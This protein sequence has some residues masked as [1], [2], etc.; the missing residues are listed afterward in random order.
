MP[1]CSR[2]GDVLSFGPWRPQA[3]S[4][5]ASTLRT[6]RPQC[7]AACGPPFGAERQAVM[8]SDHVDEID[9]DATREYLDRLQTYLDELETQELEA[10]AATG[11]AQKKRTL[12]ENMASIRRSTAELLIVTNQS[13]LDSIAAGT[14][15]RRDRLELLRDL[16]HLR[17]NFP[18]DSLD[19]EWVGFLAGHPEIRGAY[20]GSRS[21][22]LCAERG[23][24]AEYVGWHY[25]VEDRVGYYGAV[26]D[27]S[28]NQLYEAVRRAVKRH[29]GP[30]TA[31]QIGDELWGVDHDHRDSGRFGGYMSS[32]KR[33]KALFDVH[34]ET[35]P[36]RY[37]L[38]GGN[39]AA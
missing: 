30:V 13:R 23:L 9:V 28:W 11:F 27:V 26:G 36:N 37:T 14:E 6:G 17:K 7:L 8:P 4:S 34:R 35:R 29:G 19:A 16:A 39:D 33:G 20:I 3:P 2:P 22:E 10:E 12:D 21:P 38:A 15:T 1:P 24:D 32:H 25:R 18:E 5:K 31:V